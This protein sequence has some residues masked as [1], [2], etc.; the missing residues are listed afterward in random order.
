MALHSEGALVSAGGEDEKE[1]IDASLNGA[2]HDLAQYGEVD[3]VDGMAILSLVGKE[4]KNMVGIAG[5]FF[6]ILGENS[7]NIEMISQG[8]H[9][10]FGE[11][12]SVPWL[13]HG[14]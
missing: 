10:H 5:K 7:V 12:R 8:R 6:S 2:L 14:F 3:M 1:I 9:G 11:S 4:M 13:T